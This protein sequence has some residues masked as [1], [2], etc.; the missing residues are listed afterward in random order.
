MIEDV[1]NFNCTRY[2][3]PEC[4]AADSSDFD[5]EWINH[6]IPYQN[7]NLDSCSR[8]QYSVNENDGICTASSFNQS[9]MIQCDR[10]VIKDNEHTLA[11]HV[12][13]L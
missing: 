9:N 5:A 3:I 2:L 6:A 11:S 4:E 12:R 13:L 1:S 10:F 8:Y 7:D